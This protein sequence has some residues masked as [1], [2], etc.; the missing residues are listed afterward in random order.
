MN[1]YATYHLG[2]PVWHCRDWA[3]SVYAGTVDLSQALREYSKILNTVEAN[4]VFYAIP[5]LS[6]IERW[7]AES[8]DG[9]RFCPKFPKAI[10]HER[11]LIDAETETA[12]FIK[13]LDSLAHGDRLGP[14]FLQL[15][16]SFNANSY[17]QLK[18]FLQ[19]LPKD[20]EYAVEARHVSWYDKGDNEQQL[21]DLLSELGMDK[22]IFDSRPLFVTESPDDDERSA[23]SRKPQTPVRKSSLSSNPFL[24]FVGQNDIGAN[25]HWIKEWAPI[26]NKW[27]LEKKQPYIFAH[28]PNEANAPYFARQIHQQI[29][30]LN[31]TLPEFPAFASDFKK[32][33]QEQEQLDL[34]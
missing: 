18:A 16:P 14:S 32:E 8:E 4:S 2:C 27:I 19:Q 20:F 15:P 10:S 11:R 17:G 5:P 31:P 3:G 1:E 22:V 25:D 12:A 28:C 7:M 29:R 9:F 34:F 6:T 30:K 23:Q 13:I 33:R 26:I 24:R 21:D